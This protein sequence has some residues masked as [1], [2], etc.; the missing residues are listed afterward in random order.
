NAVNSVQTG[1]NVTHQ[2]IHRRFTVFMLQEHGNTLR[3]RVSH[4]FT[5][6]FDKLV[7]CIS[8]VTLEVVVITLSTRPDNEVCAQSRREVYPTFERINTLTPQGLIRIDKSSQL[9]GWIG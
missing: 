7:P 1:R 2:N 5:N 9:V 6:A 4:H 8:I 3:R